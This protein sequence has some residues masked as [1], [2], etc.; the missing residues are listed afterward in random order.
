LAAGIRVF[1]AADRLM[2][3][4]PRTRDCWPGGDAKA[5]A[6]A[7]LFE[8]ARAIIAAVNARARQSA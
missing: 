1:D 6:A 3:G 8:A 2:S 4:A 7:F 5:I